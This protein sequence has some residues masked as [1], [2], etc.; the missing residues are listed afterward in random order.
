MKSYDYVPK[1]YQLSY[2][3]HLLN[4]TGVF[5]LINLLSVVIILPLL[6]GFLLFDWSEMFDHRS[7][8]SGILF[9]LVFAMIAMVVVHELIHGFFFRKFSGK[10][11]T[12]KFHG[13]AASASTPGI[14]Y[15][16]KY[17]L[18]IGLAPAVILNIL[19]LLGSFLLPSVFGLMSYLLL[20]VHIS[21]CA[22]DFYVAWILRK[23]KEDT[24]I[25]DTGIG[26]KIYEYNESD[27]QFE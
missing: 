9:L 10:K 25:E 6:P 20:V 11:V 2:D 18:I 21:A 17:Y 13:W 24:Y 15:R 27:I 19:F 3:L 22:G 26:M 4:N 1:G 14:Y 12:Y 5:V 8:V 16:K 7:I 23:Y